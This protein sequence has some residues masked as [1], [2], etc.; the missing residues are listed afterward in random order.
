MRPDR[1][2]DNR[3]A[4]LASLP[5]YARLPPL[6]GTHS[7]DLAIIGG[8]ITGVSTAWHMA[9]RF[10]DRRVVLLE[11]RELGN[12]ASGRNG[13]QVLNGINGVEP[14]EP[15]L[16][17]KIYAATRAGIDLVEQLAGL[18]TVDCGFTRRGC[19]EVYT[20]PK[21]AESAHARL[22]A[23]RDWGPPLRWL[24]GDALGIHGACGG[25]LDSSAG[26]INCAALL[27]GL[28]PLLLARGVEVFEQTPV[29]K[30]E[31]GPSITLTTP[32]GSVRAP[33]IVLAT[34]AY[35][36]LLG[37]FRGG[38]LPLH[39]HIVATA[40]LAPERWAAAGFSDHDG[41]SDDL[42][43]IAYGARSSDG[44]LV[45]GGGSNAAYTNHFGGS[46]VFRPPARGAPHFDAV[47][48]RLRG[49]F[50][51]FAD[52]PISHRWT[53]TLGITFDRVC[54][55]GVGGPHRNIYHALGYSGHGLALGAL[56]GQVL[57][58]LYSGD[59]EPWRELP[60]YQRRLPLLPPEP[61]RWLGYQVYT[62]LTGRSPRAR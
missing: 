54:S 7:A 9:E 26:Q 44:R 18:S 60:F 49:Y 51:N 41:F 43:R 35:T 32:E 6:R 29:M 36:P 1:L 40:P 39:S 14:R 30:V 12:G 13:G 25:V 42:D 37:F 15:E 17:R 16:A 59:H 58:D 11:A 27:R 45:F 4:W 55:M 62:R 47:E 24:P 33:A 5:H 48:A 8:G 23:Q 31:P 2:D 52:A 22:E 3:S 38:I 28:R 10:P 56:A 21:S 20:T 57:R 19:L 53:G 61:L 46:P 50:P 34:N